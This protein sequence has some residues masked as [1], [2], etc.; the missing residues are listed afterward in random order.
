MSLGTDG[1]FHDK[2]NDYRLKIRVSTVRFCPRP[3]N[4]QC[5]NELKIQQKLIENLMIV[6]FP[7]QA[8]TIVICFFYCP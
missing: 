8:D 2:L 5:S 1:L 3:P 7:L 4:S 6:N